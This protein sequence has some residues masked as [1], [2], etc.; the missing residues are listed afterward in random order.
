MYCFVNKYEPCYLS[1]YGN[2][3]WGNIEFINMTHIYYDVC[4]KSFC[5]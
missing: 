4:G 3:E 5:L 2:I 1:E